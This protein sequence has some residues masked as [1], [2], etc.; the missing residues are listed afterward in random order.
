MECSRTA[1]LAGGKTS[2]PK[3]RKARERKKKKTPCT[4]VT[5]AGEVAVQSLTKAPSVDRREEKSQG[6]DKGH[7]NLTAYLWCARQ[8]MFQ[9]LVAAC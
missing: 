5:G 1:T 3:E 6:A 9:E 8:L 4:C 7:N 2:D